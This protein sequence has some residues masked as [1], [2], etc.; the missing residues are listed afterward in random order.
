MSPDHPREPTA[1][2]GT[3]GATGA[4]GSPPHGSDAEPAAAS[5]GGARSVPRRR[6]STIRVRLTLF[7]GAVFALCGAALLLISYAIVRESL[8]RDEGTSN[9]RVIE[10][11][12][13]N[14]Q[15]VDFFYNLPVP[16]A[17]SGRQ[18][19]NVGDVIA[20]VQQD[21]RNDALHQLLIGSSLALATMLVV[22]VAVG[23]LAAGRA[24]RPVGRLT[25]R[26]RRLSEDNLHERLSL[27]GPDDELKE[28]GDTLDGMLERLDRAFGAQRDFAAN[29]SHELRTPLA[30]M[31]AEADLVLADPRATDRERQLAMIVREQTGRSEGLLNALLALARSESTMREREE[32]DLADVAADVVSERIEAADRAGM[33]IDVELDDVSVVGDRWLL[34]RVVANLV[35]NAIKY[36][37]SGGWLGLVV[38]RRGGDAVLSVSNGGD[39]LTEAQVGE[40]LEPFRRAGGDSRPGFGLGMAIVRSVVE[41]HDGRLDV[42]PR[43]GGGLDVEVR[44]PAV[45]SGSAG[46]ASTAVQTDPLP[47]SPHRPLP[48]PDGARTSGVDDA[49]GGSLAPSGSG[50]VGEHDAG[51]DAGTAVPSRPS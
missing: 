34:D 3:R 31:Q 39:R 4:A 1:D 48:Q 27:D 28:L 22:A 18:A 8:Q 14:R 40:L 44:L 11:Y 42:R 25:T 26:A 41:A 46:L 2:P 35:D 23:W 38:V 30:V 10:T 20:G 51:A 5:G 15:Q 32:V 13:Y 33:R 47:P 19:G 45:T 24:L 12:G 17:S 43:P 50:E 49:A 37:E 29:V 7:Y 36:G 9:Q 6:R 21:I 16:P